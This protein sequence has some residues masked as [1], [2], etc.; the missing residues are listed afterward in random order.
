M[1]LV[2][3]VDHEVD[4]DRILDKDV[5]DLAK[6]RESRSVL[7]SSI[8]LTVI[9]YQNHAKSRAISIST[10]NNAKPLIFQVEKASNYHS[11]SIDQD[12]RRIF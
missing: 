1:I 5:V 3:L 12:H 11:E 2:E 9:I 6:T 4:S 7:T 8:C 10:R